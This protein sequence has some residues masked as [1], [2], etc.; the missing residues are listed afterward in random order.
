MSYFGCTEN[1]I[2]AE[3][4]IKISENL[5]LTAYQVILDVVEVFQNRGVI[6]VSTDSQVFYTMLKVL[7]S[8]WT[9]G[10]I[11]GVRNERRKSSIQHH[12]TKKV[13]V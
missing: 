11:A 10:Y 1:A 2:P 5:P 7:G 13:A 4:A 6:E 3:G 8:I 12:T 9:S